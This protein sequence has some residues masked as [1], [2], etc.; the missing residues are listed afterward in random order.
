MKNKKY[1]DKY[2]YVQDNAGAFLIRF[3]DILSQ[4][5]DTKRAEKNI[6]IQVPNRIRKKRTVFINKKAVNFREENDTFPL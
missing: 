4:M 5:Y 2:E 1:R 6:I 3:L